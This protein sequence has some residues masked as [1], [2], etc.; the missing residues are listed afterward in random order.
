MGV[1]SIKIP[2]EEELE[3]K[4]KKVEQ[5]LSDVS[6]DWDK[7]IDKLSMIKEVIED[8]DSPVSEKNVIN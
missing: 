4:V 6:Q 7:M 3:E 2:T 8:P 1:I 5:E